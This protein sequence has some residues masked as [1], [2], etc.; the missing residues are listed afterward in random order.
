MTQDSLVEIPQ[1][2]ATLPNEEACLSS[3]TQVKHWED[4]YRNLLTLS[5]CMPSIPIDWKQ[6]EYLVKGCQ[7]KAWLWHTCVHERYY[8]LGQS[9]SKIVQA[10]MILVLST[11]QGKTA[12]EIL[13]FKVHDFLRPLGLER[14]LSSSR[15]G[16]ISA[17]VAKI[18]QSLS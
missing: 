14:H 8:W 3:L 5:K 17:M 4:R 9:D 16:G 15:M 12:T 6:D 11:L 7:S 13:S 10:L 18:Q 2:L 1:F